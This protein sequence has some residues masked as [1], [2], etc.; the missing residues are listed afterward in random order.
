MGQA[1]VLSTEGRV[2]QGMGVSEVAPR[3]EPELCVLSVSM[4]RVELGEAMG[5]IWPRAH[6][7]AKGKGFGGNTGKDIKR[8]SGNDVR[9]VRDYSNAVPGIR[10]FVGGCVS[11]WGRV[12][13]SK[14]RV[15]T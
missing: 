15:R 4:S 6:K 14:G 3:G 9:E 1:N 10:S 8:V 7:G 2:F 12:R 13:K 11:S 5:S